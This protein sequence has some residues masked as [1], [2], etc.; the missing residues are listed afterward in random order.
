MGVNCARAGVRPRRRAERATRCSARARSAPTR[1]RSARLAV[2]WVDACQAEG[3]LG[4]G[5]HFPGLGRI[6]GAS[7]DEMQAIAADRDTLH[8]ADLA[9]FRALIDRGVASMMM[10]SVAYPALDPSRLPAS[11][12]REI[13]QWL[14]RQ[15][16]RFDGMLIRRCRAHAGRARRHDRRGRGRGARHRRRLRRDPRADRSAR[17]DRRP[18]GGVA[19]ARAS[20]HVTNE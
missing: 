2:E 6:V 19:R 11:Q 20:K 12:S 5:E 17:D 10:A 9:P 15:Q 16:L 18:R 1:R 4:C 8:N 7:D 14:L 13:V 3:V